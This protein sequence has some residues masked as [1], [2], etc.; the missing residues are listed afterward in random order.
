MLPIKQYIELRTAVLRQSCRLADKVKQRT[1][2]STQMNEGA[3]TAHIKQSEDDPLAIELGA[4]GPSLHTTIE[5]DIDL[6]SIAHKAYRDDPLFAK[7]LSHPEA[8]PHFRICDQLIWT[9][10]QMGRDVVCIP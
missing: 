5:R 4:N 8:H 1:L 9:K 2:E 7:I 3:T 6:A 10:K